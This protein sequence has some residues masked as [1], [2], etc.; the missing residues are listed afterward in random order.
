MLDRTG[1]LYGA[2]GEGGAS[3][4]GTVYKIDRNGKYTLLYSFSGKSDGCEP[5]GNFATD[6]NGNLYGAASACGDFNQGTIF[7]LSSTGSFT[8]LYAFGADGSQSANAPFGGV[9]RDRNGNLYGTTLF[10]GEC[11]TSQSGCGTVFKLSP[12]GSMTV[13][14]SFDGYADGSSPWC[15]VILDAA[16]NLYGTTTIGGQGDAGTVW[17]IAP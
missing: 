12:G 2:T 15:N 14:H 3:N 17:K 6:E 10:G 1:N 5:L 11:S 8:L 4:Y 13:L 7:K 16:G 9:I